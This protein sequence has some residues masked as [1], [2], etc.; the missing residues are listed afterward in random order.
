VNEGDRVTH[1]AEHRKKCAD[2]DHGKIV[3][4]FERKEAKFVHKFATVNWS[5]GTTGK[6]PVANLF[7]CTC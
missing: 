4:L 1:I 6:H 2:K 7:P 3:H 5:D